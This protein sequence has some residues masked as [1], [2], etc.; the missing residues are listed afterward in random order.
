MKKIIL[1]LL[2]LLL[3]PILVFAKNTCNQ[4]DIVIKS[5][6][7]SDTNK[8]AEESNSP[9]IDNNKIDLDLK[10]YNVGD[11]IE[12]NII[13]KNDSN[14]DYYFDNNSIKMNKDYLEYVIIND[15]EVIRS[16]EEKTIK[17]KVTYKAQSHKQ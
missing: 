16:G 7:L 1:F 3:C 9:I 2:I 17:L 15:S 14:E 5:I 8:Y 10:M 6:S 4:Q 12:Y 13:I 11:S